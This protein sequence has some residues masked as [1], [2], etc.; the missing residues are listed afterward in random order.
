MSSEP[1]SL[2]KEYGLLP[3]A[4]S[5]IAT[6]SVIILSIY[7]ANKGDMSTVYFGEEYIKCDTSVA[8]LINSTISIYKYPGLVL[9]FVSL[10]SLIFSYIYD[11]VLFI[12]ILICFVIFNYPFAA[13][14]DNAKII[15]SLSSVDRLCSSGNY[16]IAAIQLPILFLSSYVIS[17][18]IVLLAK[19]WLRRRTENG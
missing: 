4:L 16:A 14:L 13:L 3:I 10:A 19:R 9:I 15:L 5:G 1:R 17:G 8:A 6:V 18:N 7:H 2:Q 12:F 11:R